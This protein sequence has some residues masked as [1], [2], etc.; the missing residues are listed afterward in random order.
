MFESAYYVCHHAM[1]ILVDV[2]QVAL[3]CDNSVCVSHVIK[4][5]CFFI[6]CPVE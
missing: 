6:A 2:S 4:S 1:S 5:V 3:I